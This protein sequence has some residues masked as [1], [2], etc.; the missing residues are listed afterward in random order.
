MN[1]IIVQRNNNGHLAKINIE[2]LFK[3][4]MKTEQP[5]QVNL[6]KFF[7]SFIHCLDF[8][9]FNIFLLEIK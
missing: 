4:K 2:Q 8:L 7:H 5:S 9:F 3:I 6:N 1:E